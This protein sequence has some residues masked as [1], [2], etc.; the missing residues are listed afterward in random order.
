[1]THRNDRTASTGED[2]SLVATRRAEGRTHGASM[3]DLVSELERDH[4]RLAEQARVSGAA[5]EAGDMIR[6]ARQAAGLS[7]RELAE[8]AGLHQSAISSIER[9]EGKDGPTYRKMRAIADALGMRMA[10]MSVEES[11]RPDSQKIIKSYEGTKKISNSPAI[12]WRPSIKKWIIES[13]HENYKSFCNAHLKG[14]YSAESHAQ[15]TLNNAYDFWSISKIT[16]AESVHTSRIERDYVI[17]LIF[18]A[19]AV[20]RTETK[21]TAA[22]SM[23]RNTGKPDRSA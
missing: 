11:S 6:A 5:V 22:A 17:G 19:D 4:P 7:Q 20:G 15:T 14:S 13:H 16:P 9:G 3:T 8:A 12:E 2:A 18:P 10:F 23:P 21:P 1:M